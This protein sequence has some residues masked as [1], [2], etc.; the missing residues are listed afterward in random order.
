MSDALTQEVVKEAP[1]SDVRMLRIFKSRI[2]HIAYIFEDGETACFVRRTHETAG[3]YLTDQADKIKELEK[4]CLA[5]GG[6]MHLY[7]D[8]QEMEVRAD[9]ADPA[10]AY[11]NRI[12][13]EE[14]E[15]LIKE[16][17]DQNQ[18]RGASLEI[19]SIKTI[20]ASETALKAALQGI[21]NSESLRGGAVDSNG[22]AVK[23]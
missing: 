11:R 22:A 19:N 4:V 21:S 6:H 2:S 7:M 23:K 9:L 8:P 12:R 18:P 3:H 13:E 14:R 5:R 1:P 20:P 10:V 17:G 15:K 16:L